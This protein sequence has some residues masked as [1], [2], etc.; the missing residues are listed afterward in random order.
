MTPDSKGIGELPNNWED[1]TKAQLE[2]LSE[3]GSYGQRLIA[4]R[5]LAASAQLNQA[6]AL[7]RKNTQ[8][9]NALRQQ[10]KDERPPVTG[11]V[12]RDGDFDL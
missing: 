3:H 10:I 6:A 12:R 2:F 1:C 8:A 7:D 11:L 5:W 4:N 9:A